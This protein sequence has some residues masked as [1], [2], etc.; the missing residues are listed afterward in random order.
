M[1]KLEDMKTFIRIVEAGSIT[2]A[3]E[4]LNT[5]KSAISKRLTN[6]EHSLGITLLQRT[7]R[8]QVLTE[9]GKVYYKE[10]LRLIDE[11]NELESGLQNRTSALTGN[12][13]IA[14][15]LSFGLSHLVQ[16]LNEFQSQHDGITLDVD[17]NDRKVDI[18]NEGFDLAVRI[19]ELKDS[20]ML[21]RKLSE[22]KTL[23]VASNEY[24]EKFGIPETPSDLMAGH[25]GLM[26]SNTSSSIAFSDGAGGIQH[27]KIPA[28]L[29]SNNGDYLC[30]AA[31]QGMGIVNSPDFICYQ[32]VQNGNLVPLLKDYYVSPTMGVYAVYPQTRYLSAKVS[33]LIQYLNDYYGKEPYWKIV[34]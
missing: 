33:A 6:L 32:Y 27:L 9:S 7:T 5:A 11:I 28:Y 26:Y 22:V 31:L 20:N 15:P 34:K 21:A 16:P 19:G 1:N 3:A 17:F 23:L 25:R 29:Y 12:I 2:L 14:V 30:S 13:K 24:L 4:Q 10:C 18:I 8:S